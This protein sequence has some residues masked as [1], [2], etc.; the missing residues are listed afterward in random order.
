[1]PGVDTFDDPALDTI[2]YFE[3][4]RDHRSPQRRVRELR[5]AAAD[6]RRD[7]LAESP[8]EYFRSVELVR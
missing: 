7:M 5:A 2:D 6:F 8:V 1:M 3:G 4:A